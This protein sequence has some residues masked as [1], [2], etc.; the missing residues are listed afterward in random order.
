[1]RL[2]KELAESL[3]IRAGSKIIFVKKENSFEV[4]AEIST[5]PRK[6]TLENIVAGITPA[7]RHEEFDWGK[8]MG[9]EIW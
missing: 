4:K 3:S 2:P 6:Y 1:M 9:R 7:N 5:K 8:P